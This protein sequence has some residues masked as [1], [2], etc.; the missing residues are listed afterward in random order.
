MKNCLNCGT[1]IDGKFCSECGQAANTTRINWRHMAEELQY[2]L[3]HVNKGMFYTIKAMLTKPGHTVQDYLSGK[4]VSYIKPFTYLLI[5]GSV[6]ALIIHFFNVYPDSEVSSSTS[7]DST[8]IDFPSFYNFYYGHYSII[9]LL[10]IPFYALSS[11][12]LFRRDGYNY[13]EHL[14]LYSYIHGT[15]VIILL[16][17]YPFFYFLHSKYVYDLT[18]VTI[19]L[20]NIWA[21][22]QFIKTRSWSNA[23]LKAI[24]SIVLTIIVLFILAVIVVLIIM[25]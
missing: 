14:V 19:L 11:Y 20:Y 16:F 18:Q 9:L 7:S 4:R 15:K 10:I 23:I 17:F 25:K 21:L 3:L 6:Y 5:W 8:I 24:L 2:S 13:I 12:L 22:A 1:R